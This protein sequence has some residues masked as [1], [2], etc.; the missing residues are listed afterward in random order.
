MLKACVTC[1]N[2][3]LSNCRGE[4]VN[5][6]KGVPAMKSIETTTVKPLIEKG[7]FFRI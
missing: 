6:A 7:I 5:I 3:E 2:Q 4:D 1:L